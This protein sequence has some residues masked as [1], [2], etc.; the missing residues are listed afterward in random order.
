MCLSYNGK[1]QIFKS[2]DE[3]HNWLK[4][5]NF[6]LPKDIKLH[7]GTEYKSQ[8]H[9][10]HQ[11]QFIN[12]N[13]GSG[14]WIFKK[15]HEIYN[16][17]EY[18]EIS[19][20]RAKELLGKLVYD[21]QIALW[22][23]EN[24]KIT[25]LTEDEKPKNIGRFSKFFE[26]PVYLTKDGKEIKKGDTVPWT[27]KDKEELERYN[28][29]FKSTIYK[30]GKD[31]EKQARQY[32]TKDD[33][34]LHAFTSK[35]D[36]QNKKWYLKLKSKVDNSENQYLSSN[37]KNGD[38]LVNNLNDAKSFES[39]SDALKAYHQ[40]LLKTENPS[41]YFS[42]ISECFGGV[43]TGT[44]GTAV[45]YVGNKKESSFKDEFLKLLDKKTDDITLKEDDTPE[46]F[47]T[48]IDSTPD[49]PLDDVESPMNT[50]TPDL[51]MNTDIPSNDAPDLNFGDISIS[52]GN[53]NYGPEDTEENPMPSIPQDEY[54]IIDVLI[55]DTDETDIKVKLQ[56]M[57]TGE[58]EIKELS[59]I[60]I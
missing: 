34:K 23:D 30:M 47:A 59:E 12:G 21:V 57:E 28:N 1:I 26:D 7:E 11:L 8:L 60:D 43:T 29:R 44:L 48:N 41:I 37:W 3:L 15:A 39:K 25:P 54:K 36:N 50:E 4:E 20:E 13:V 55:N 19:E 52:G 46:D 33:L 56:N 32:M 2:V 9:P 42:P 51:D 17:F 38:L 31:R 18:N 45:Q 35:I 5:N 53:G 14:S 24:G 6:P 16:S 40:V 27:D 58:I 49:M 22:G 10:W